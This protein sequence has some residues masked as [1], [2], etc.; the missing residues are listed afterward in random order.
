MIYLWIA[1]LSNSASVPHPHLRPRPYRSWYHS[2]VNKRPSIRTNVFYTN[3]YTIIFIYKMSYRNLISLQINILHVFF[4][5]LPNHFAVVCLFAF[6]FSSMSI[7]RNGNFLGV[8]ACVY[9]TNL[10]PS[11]KNYIFRILYY[12]SKSKNVENVKNLLKEWW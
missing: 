7:S 4:L 3:I 5:L 12:F 1:R 2:V 8:Y 9:Q 10:C 6:F 11:R